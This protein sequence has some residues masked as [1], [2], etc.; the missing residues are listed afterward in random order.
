MNVLV[1]GA[2]G[3]V[4]SA[5]ARVLLRQGNAVVGLV[6]ERARGRW[7]EEFGATLAAGEMER[8]QTYE[9]LVAQVD[10]VI[11][12]AQSKPSGRWTRRRIT[13]MHHSDAL[14][15]RT[16]AHACL[17]QGKLFVYTSGAIAHAGVGDEWISE[18]TPLRPCLLAKGHAEMVSELTDLHRDQGAR[19]LVVTPGFVY[20]AGSFLRQTVELMLRGRYRVVGN[21][22][23]YWGLVHVE[24]LAEVY[25]LSLE[26]GT[27]GAN[28]FVC[29]DEPLRRREVI[30]RIADALGVHRVGR[31]PGWVVGLWLGSPLVEAITSSIR[32]R[33]DL[34]KQQL[35]WVPR[36]RSF[37][38]GLPPAL[39]Q[40][41][42][43]G[44]G[45]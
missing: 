41:Q 43:L 26:R 8:P 45:G 28:Y 22:A 3:F 15:T 5:V 36:Y 17:K 32:M 2:T 33:N 1:T 4:G 7:L 38:E 20:G 44:V 25:A 31:V 14:M 9:P 35:G 30:D 16:L 42:A 13:A 11:H 18:A 10:A 34:V 27:A 23:N 19:V 24:D 40:L 37:A 39:Q 6:R 29:D 12:A 21:G